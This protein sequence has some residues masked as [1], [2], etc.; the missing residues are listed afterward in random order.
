V[1]PLALWA[2]VALVALVAT[3]CWAILARKTAVYVTSGI[4]FTGWSW[5]AIT[6]GDTALILARTGEPVWIRESVASL[7]YVALALAI[8]SLVVF[9]LRLLGAYPTPQENAAETE[10]SATT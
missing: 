4:S 6:G 1:T 8:I 10:E 5:L 3:A 7:Q 2:A 9:S